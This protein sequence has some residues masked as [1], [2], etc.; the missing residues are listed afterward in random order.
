MSNLPTPTPH[1]MSQ[2]A[3]QPTVRHHPLKTTFVGVDHPSSTPESPVAQYRGI[4]YAT[5]PARFRRSKLVTSYPDVVDATKFGCAVP[6][7]AV[8]DL[9]LTIRFSPICPQPRPVFSCQPPFPI[10]PLTEPTAEQRE[11]ILHQDEFECLNLN[12]TCPRRAA[13]SISNP[14]LPV[15]LWFH[16]LVPYTYVSRQCTF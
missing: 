12:I 6:P 9:G 7:F 4:Q 14:G 15:M 11:H 3:P 1:A 16:G 8:L 10:T 2:P 13:A 5:L